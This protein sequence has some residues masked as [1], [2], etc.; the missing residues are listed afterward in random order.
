MNRKS[1]FHP[2]KRRHNQRVRAVSNQ[3]GE[4]RS[5]QGVL[6]LHPN[7]YGFL[8]DESTH[9]LP[10]Q[11]DSFVPEGLI[12]SLGLRAG[13]C[14]AG[15]AETR[16]RQK[17]HRLTNI[18]DVDGIAPDGLTNVRDIDSLTPVNPHE[19]LCLESGQESISMRVI[20]LLTPIGKGQRTMIVAPPRSGKTILLRQIANSIAKNHPSV[21]LFGLLV[22]E[23][24]EEVTEMR[25][26]INGELLASTLDAQPEC[27]VRLAQLVVARCQRL[28]ELGNDVVLLI[29]S[30]T[31]LARAF[32]KMSWVNGAMGP[33][34]LKTRALEI[35]KQLFSSAR[36]FR[37]CGSLTIIATALIET[38]NRMDE[39]IYQEFKGTG[40]M[41]IVLDER[42]AERRVW[43]AMD[44]SKSKTRRDEL[45]HDEKTLH[46]VTMLRR[47][48]ATLHP[49]EAMERLAEQLGRHSSNAEFISRIINAN[50][51]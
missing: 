1:K 19:Q 31:R 13:F 3:P 37:E 47:T 42:L 43:P 6:E 17:G 51:L 10:S 41:E 49:I 24:P 29:D 15:V 38:E 4:K 27:H 26:A 35:P 2:T 12:E 22:D 50:S 18:R 40:N 30:L 9:Y 14:V 7:G 28:V 11:D 44:I 21:R 32:N 48:L 34:G 16:D 25:Q 46:A 8:R 45:L 39:A 33:G 5:V 20:D 36:A 23:R